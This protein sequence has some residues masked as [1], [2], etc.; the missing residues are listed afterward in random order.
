MVE[1]LE[2][3]RRLEAEFAVTAPRLEKV[4]E[5]VDA[6]ILREIARMTGGR[7]FGVDGVEELMA[8]IQALPERESIDKRVRIW[9]H[10]AW[11][12]ALLLA[13]AVYWTGRKLTGMV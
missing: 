3:G 4:G 9:S 13:L 8:T 11:G 12:G 2:H 7:T 1:S 5:P 6:A 10:P